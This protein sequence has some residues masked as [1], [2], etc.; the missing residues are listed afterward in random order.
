MTANLG[1]IVTVY[2]FNK[3]FHIAWDKAMVPSTIRAGF[4]AT[5]V[6]PLE[7][8]TLKRGEKPLDTY[9]YSLVH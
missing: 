7:Q 2:K 3:L 6:Y 9:L 5:G 8:Y 4:K 1:R